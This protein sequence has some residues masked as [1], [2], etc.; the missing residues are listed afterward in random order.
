MVLNEMA[1]LDITVIRGDTFCVELT[2][3]VKNG[4]VNLTGYTFLGQIRSMSGVLLATFTI[5]ILDAAKGR[6]ELMIPAETTAAIDTV[7]NKFGKYDV[8]W[9]TGAGRVK[10]FLGGKVIFETDTSY[11]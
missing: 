3:S 9:T 1:I 6:L 8:Q 5:S 11:P 10:T 7:T 4:A 2:V